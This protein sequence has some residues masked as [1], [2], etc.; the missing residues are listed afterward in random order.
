[1]KFSRNIS[2]TGSALEEMQLVCQFIENFDADRLI[3]AIHA[4]RCDRDDIV[5]IKAD[6]DIQNARLTKQKISLEK[7]AQ[8]FNK[9]WATD[10]NKVFDTALYTSNKIKS[11][12]KGIKDLFKRFCPRIMKK[13]PDGKEQPTAIV[14]S[15]ISRKEYQLT[16]FGIEEYPQIVKDLFVSMINFFNNLNECI[17]IS[18]EVIIE[19]KET[20]GDTKKLL[21]LFLKALE[22]AVKRN[23]V[24]IEALESDPNLRN[25]MIQ[26]E[27]ISSDSEN[28]I[29]AKYK[30]LGEEGLAVEDF[31]SHTPKDIDKLAIQIAIEEADTE[32]PTEIEVLLFNRNN[33]EKIKNIRY[34][35]A[36]YDRLL[37]DTKCKRGYIPALHLFAFIEWCNV[38]D[39]VNT[40]LNYFKKRY[41]AANGKFKVPG[42]TAISGA[43]NKLTKSGTNSSINIDFHIKLLL[44]E[45]NNTM[46][47]YTA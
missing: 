2:K 11:G 26:N 30:K 36:N 23:L 38:L 28:K 25:A 33:E 41:L 16:L 14:H 18:R 39:N 4:R 12:Y 40:F 3:S 19:E 22:E 35:I 27:M 46:S 6:I 34:I 17:K 43:K 44:L 1:M 15:S 42:P 24:V 9:Q 21:E 20:E 7:F 32:K 37:K 31:H 29:L 10:N 45:R 5:S 47:V 8:T 13:L